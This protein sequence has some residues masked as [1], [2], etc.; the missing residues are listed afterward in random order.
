P[1]LCL[2][3]VEAAI[4]HGGIIEAY[5]A[6]HPPQP[7][8]PGRRGMA[9]EHHEG[10]VPDALG[11]ESARQLLERRQGETKLRTLVRQFGAKVE[12]CRARD[13]ALVVVRP[14]AFD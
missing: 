7:G 14:T 3:L 8:R 11:G 10:A 5:G 6:Q 4:E 1:V 2:P 9:V 13:V 12:E